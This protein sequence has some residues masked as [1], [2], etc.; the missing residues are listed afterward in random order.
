[1]NTRNRRA[2]MLLRL[3]QDEAADARRAFED[4]RARQEH[5]RRRIADL[6]RALAEQDGVA[7]RVL[8]ASGRADMSPY[9]AAVTEIRAGL[10]EQRAL[11]RPLEPMAAQARRRL[12][13]AL[14]DRKAAEAL[15]VRLRVAEAER[16]ERAEVRAVDD[17]HTVRLA[18]AELAGT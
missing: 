11:L 5:H 3:R 14:A 15:A 2:A 6:E 10:A 8:A 12:L 7:R 4:I 16:A 18:A 1:M 13:A 17:T 9:R